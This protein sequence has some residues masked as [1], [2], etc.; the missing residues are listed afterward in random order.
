MLKLRL[1]IFDII[2]EF[3]IKGLAR[4]SDE[5]DDEE[6][7]QLLWTLSDFVCTVGL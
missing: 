3:A 5:H 4:E 2:L 6:D 7:L 1:D